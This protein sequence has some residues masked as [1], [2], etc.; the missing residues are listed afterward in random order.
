MSIDQ[1]RLEGYVS[2]LRL[3]KPLKEQ[4]AKVGENCVFFTGITNISVCRSMVSMQNGF[5][6]PPATRR[7]TDW[8]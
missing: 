2:V 1:C 7:P 4:Y 3:S 8:T 5:W 6:T